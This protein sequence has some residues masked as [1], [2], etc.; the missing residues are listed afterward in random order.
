MPED[1]FDFQ[2]ISHTTLPTQHIKNMCRHKTHKAFL[3]L[4][5]TRL[6]W[7]DVNKKEKQRRKKDKENKKRKPGGQLSEDGLLDKVSLMLE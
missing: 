4:S 1:H 6:S 7:K 3:R 5:E 2:D